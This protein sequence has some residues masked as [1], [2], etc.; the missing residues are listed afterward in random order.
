MQD[1]GHCPPKYNE[2]AFRAGKVGV[3]IFR[4]RASHPFKIEETNVKPIIEYSMEDGN[5]VLFEVDRAAEEGIVRAA[6]PGEIAGRARKTLEEALDGVKPAASAVIRK[7][8]GLSDP[9][10][11]VEVEF[12]LKLSADVGAVVASTGVEAHYKISL[13]WKRKPDEGAQDPEKDKHYEI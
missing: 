5:I 10:D 2:I 3:P 8:R 13:T 11:E 7:L 1:A 6:K 4:C 9:A 12:G